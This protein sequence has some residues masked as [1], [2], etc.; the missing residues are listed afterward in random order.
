MRIAVKL[1]YILFQ[2]SNIKQDIIFVAIVAE[3]RAKPSG[4]RNDYICRFKYLLM[5]VHLTIPVSI[6]LEIVV[7][8]VR[9]WEMLHKITVVSYQ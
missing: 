6:L 8:S 4:W 7:I 3:L 9:R 5:K 1:C 2:I